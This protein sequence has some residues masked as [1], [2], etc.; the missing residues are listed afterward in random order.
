ML[1]DLLDNLTQAH[2]ETCGSGR[3]QSNFVALS[4]QVQVLLPVNP[5]EVV[6]L[7]L[8]VVA[9]QSLGCRFFID[10]CH[11]PN[12]RVHQRIQGDVDGF[13]DSCICHDLSFFLGLL[14]H[15]HKHLHEQ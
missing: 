2:Q 7:T 15:G 11:G 5:F 4:V 14:G 12:A 1:G 6:N 10:P 13:L 9:Q 3:S 8:M